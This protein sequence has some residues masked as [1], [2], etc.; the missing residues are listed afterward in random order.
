MPIPQQIAGQKYISLTTF[1]R[2]GT[3]VRTPVWFGESDGKLY[4]ITRNDSWKY[5]R[6]RNNPE[7]EVAACT[8]R[9]RVT[10]PDYSGRARILPMEDWKAAHETIKRKYWLARLSFP[11]KKNVLVEIDFPG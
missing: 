7:V 1:K 8:I 9:G 4:V 3:G 10:G 2:D 6:I 11:N 5:K